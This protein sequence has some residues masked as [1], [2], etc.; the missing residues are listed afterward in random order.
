MYFV[1]VLKSQ[2]DSKRY[3]GFTDNLERR[4]YEHNSGLVKSTKNRRPLELIYYEKFDSKTEAMKR[5]KFFK[6]GYGRTFLST[7][8]F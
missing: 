5:E 8:G 2:K 6:T 7:K 1:Y 3:I 4:L